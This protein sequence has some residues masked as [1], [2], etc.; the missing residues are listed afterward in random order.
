MTVVRTTLF[1]PMGVVRTSAMIVGLAFLLYVSTRHTQGFVAL[2]AM[3]PVA[4]IV[5]LVLHT[6]HVTIGNDGIVLKR[7]LLRA[8]FVLHREVTGVRVEKNVIVIERSGGKPFAL[9]TSLGGSTPRDEKN[10]SALARTLRAASKNVT[11]PQSVP[12]IGRVGRSHR[13]WL[14]EL[15]RVGGADYRTAHVERD[16]L[17]SV[18]ESSESVPAE[19]VAAAIALRSTASNEDRARLDAIADGLARPKLGDHIRRIARPHVGDDA[20]VRA[21]VDASRDAT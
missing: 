20:L 5:T 19:R 2:F 12:Q 9:S 15:R 6:V 4:L 18:V 14:D 16:G 3:M 13:E 17:W 1:T 8:S 7:P 10:A 21:L 11:T